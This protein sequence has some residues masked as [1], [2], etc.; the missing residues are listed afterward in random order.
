MTQLDPSFQIFS[1]SAHKAAHQISQ[2]WLQSLQEL[3]RVHQEQAQHLALA[4]RESLHDFVGALQKAQPALQG[5]CERAIAQAQS[6][7]NDFLQALGLS[8]ASFGGQ[9]LAQEWSKRLTDASRQAAEQAAQLGKACARA[10]S[11]PLAGSRA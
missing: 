9:A 3:A 10:W 6:Q 1:L 8:S 5:S 11:L 2:A 7:G 4:T